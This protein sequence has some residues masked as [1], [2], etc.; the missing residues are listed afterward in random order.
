MAKEDGDTFTPI[1]FTKTDE[2]G[3]H[4]LTAHSPSDAVRLRFDGWSEKKTGGRQAAAPK[5]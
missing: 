3:A 1:T 5:P 4:E 2:R